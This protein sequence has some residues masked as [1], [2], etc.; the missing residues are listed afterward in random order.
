MEDGCKY[1]QV[2]QFNPTGHNAEADGKTAFGETGTLFQKCVEQGG[3]ENNDTVG[4]H[5]AMYYLCPFSSGFVVI[6][7]L[8]YL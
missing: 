6:P 2:N 3:T 7:V 4:P 5:R 8:H 1:G